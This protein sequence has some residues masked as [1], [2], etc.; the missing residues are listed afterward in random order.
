M[1]CMQD[2]SEDGTTYWYMMANCRRA[3]VAYSLYASSSA[4]GTKCK[5]SNFKESVSVPLAG[6]C[7]CV[8]VCVCIFLYCV[9][10]IYTMQILICIYITI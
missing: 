10:I 7:V 2:S 5:N 6:L 4:G 9:S 3:Q 8:F 1:G